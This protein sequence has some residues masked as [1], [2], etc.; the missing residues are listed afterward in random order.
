[1]DVLTVHAE[2]DRAPC[3]SVPQLCIPHVCTAWDYALIG[4]SS[5]A[6][7]LPPGRGAIAASRMHY[8]RVGGEGAPAASSGTR[9]VQSSE[10]RA[11][12]HRK[13]SKCVC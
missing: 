1:M 2:R 11:A 9:H 8:G 13:P 4:P 3:A 6:R 5:P 10:R 12:S 7:R